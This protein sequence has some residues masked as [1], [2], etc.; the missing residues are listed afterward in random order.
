M[1]SDG[2]AHSSAKKVS[3]KSNQRISIVKNLPKSLEL[4]I[5]LENSNGLF[6]F[7]Y[8]PIVAKDAGCEL[9]E[10]LKIQPMVSRRA[11][12]VEKIVS[13]SKEISFLR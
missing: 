12:F 5:F 6:I 13:L 9:S 11:N 4:F 3:L 10:A 8:F 1:L 7:V 2:W